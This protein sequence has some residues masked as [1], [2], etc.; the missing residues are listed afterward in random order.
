LS[1]YGVLLLA[2]LAGSAHH[3]AKFRKEP[4]RVLLTSRHYAS[5]RGARPR[6]LWAFAGY[7]SH[8]PPIG[9]E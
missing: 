3:T 8:P 9:R 6:L 2:R 7:R 1:C 5:N 4:S